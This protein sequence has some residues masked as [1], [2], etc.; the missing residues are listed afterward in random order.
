MS[1]ATKNEIVKA[2][3]LLPVGVEGFILYTVNENG[4]TQL[5]TNMITQKELSAARES[6]EKKA[7][8]KVK[9][10]PLKPVVKPEVQPV[11]TEP[12]Q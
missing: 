12:V 2:L 11:V 7:K 5:E 1:Q 9:A 4:S 6:L 3:D 8:A 10:L